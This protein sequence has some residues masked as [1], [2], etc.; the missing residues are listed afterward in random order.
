MTTQAYPTVN[1]VA[2]SWSD[3]RLSFPILGGATVKLVDVAGVKWSSKVEVGEVMGANG[4]RLL[5][6]TTGQ[7]KHES[8]VTF[9]TPGLYAFIAELRK[10][11]EKITLVSFDVIVQHTPPGDTAI[12]TT[13]VVG[14][15][16]LEWSG[17]MAE[18][19]D[20]DK[21][22]VTLHPMAIEIAGGASLL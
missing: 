9:Y 4:G 1:A 6:R 11:N 8:S 20:A 19:V 14:C 5:K 3:L 16:M 22:E 10:V 13:K 21:I 17:D 12:Y 7:I 2:P 15:R 18:G